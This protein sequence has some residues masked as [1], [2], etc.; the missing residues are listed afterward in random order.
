M[1][2]IMEF[3]TTCKPK[4]EKEDTRYDP[5]LYV[6][7]YQIFYNYKLL[8]INDTGIQSESVF[9]KFLLPR[10]TKCSCN[11]KYFISI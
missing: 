6:L 4:R 7:P 10:I 2:F 9:K 11:I 1:A 8:E 5:D 3:R